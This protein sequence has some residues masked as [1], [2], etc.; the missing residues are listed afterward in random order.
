METQSIPV[1]CAASADGKS[2]NVVSIDESAEV[3]AGLTLYAGGV[4]RVIAYKVAALQDG[5]LHKV[6][7]GAGLEMQGPGAI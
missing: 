2:V 5:A 1:D 4:E 6:E 3:Q 7:V